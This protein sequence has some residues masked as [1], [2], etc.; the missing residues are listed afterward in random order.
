[1]PKAFAQRNENAKSAR[2]VRRL[3]HFALIAVAML[4]ML[5]DQGV[6]AAQLQ[7]A[8]NQHVFCPAG[9]STMAVAQPSKARHA[10]GGHNVGADKASHLGCCDPDADHPTDNDC[11]APYCSAAP[12]RIDTASLASIPE[13][14]FRV[15]FSLKHPFLS[16]HELSPDHG[17]PR[18]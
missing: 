1:V 7:I 14:A 8:V 3:W 13:Y 15:I 11:A 6:S 4:F 9:I 5:P 18:A 17:P 12:V 2:A 16:A 10:A